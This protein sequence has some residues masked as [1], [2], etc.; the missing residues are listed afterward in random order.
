MTTN[1]RENFDKN[2]SHRTSSPEERE[3]VGART[4]VSN[5]E[6]PASDGGA[7]PDSLGGELEVW[8]ARL[9][10]SAN[11]IILP[12]KYW[13]HAPRIV[14]GM[15][16]KGALTIPPDEPDDEDESTTMEDDLQREI[17]AREAR[18]V[19]EVEYEP[20]SLDDGTD[21]EESERQDA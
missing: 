14:T 3:D 16:K 15:L 7:L 1:K 9:I 11:G 18:Y 6:G 12:R 13:P 2:A 4:P 19:E 21:D 5:Q 10:L 17:D 8:E 20:A